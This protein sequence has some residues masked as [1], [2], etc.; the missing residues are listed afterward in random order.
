MKTDDLKVRISALMNEVDQNNP[1]DKGP[2]GPSQLPAACGPLFL[3][4]A[5]EAA[6]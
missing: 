1:P 4:Y 5:G 6:A 3:P 2:R